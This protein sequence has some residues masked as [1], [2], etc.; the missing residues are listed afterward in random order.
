MT[1]IEPAEG[2]CPHGMPDPIGCYDCQHPEA[3]RPAPPPEFGSRAWQAQFPGRCVV[4]D[5]DI[6]VGQMIVATTNRDPR[7]YAHEVCA[8]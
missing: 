2:E 5:D 3:R 1:T 7:L 4:C 8:L 6:A